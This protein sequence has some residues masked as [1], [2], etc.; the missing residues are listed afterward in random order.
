LMETN[1]PTDNDVLALASSG[2]TVFLGGSFSTVG[3]QVRPGVAAI[4]AA[5]GDVRDWNAHAEGA[6][7]SLALD[8]PRLCV[9]GTFLN[10]GGG[11]RGYLAIL[12][13]ASAQAEAWSM[14]PN[15]PAHAVAICDS[16]VCTAGEF[17]FIGAPRNSLAALDL[18]TGLPT[19]WVPPVFAGEWAGHIQTLAAGGGRLY[20]GGSF[21]MIGDQYRAHLAAFDLATGTLSTWNPEAG[22]VPMAIAPSGGVIYVGGLFRSAGGRTRFGLAAL[23]AITGAATDWNPDVDGSVYSVS[24]QGSTV[25]VGGVFNRLGDIGRHS[26]AAIDAVSGAVSSWNPDASGAV[27][28][29]SQADRTTYVGGD[30]YT[31][32]DARRFGIAALGSM[33]FATPWDPNA[34]GGPWESDYGDPGV[35]CL[36]LDGG[37]V[38]MG[39]NFKKLGGLTRRGIAAVDIAGGVV[40]D[41]D[42]G[43]GGLGSTVTAI[44]VHDGKVCIGGHFESVGSASVCGLA[45]VSAAPTATAPGG[46]AA[47][48]DFE[49]LPPKPNP[50]RGTVALHC[51]IPTSSD[52]T[53]DLFD[54]AGRRVRSLLRQEGLPAGHWEIRLDCASLPS[55]IYYARMVA[56]GHGLT[57]KLVVMN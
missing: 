19:S 46:P 37:T 53:L 52:V 54:C 31:I 11:A 29:I 33:G 5:T 51:S 15:A 56:G 43:L 49:M 25:Y 21:T 2:A 7:Y 42:P 45:V 3:G 4:D 50:A 8:G 16:V 12:D 18:G 48:T 40:E 32:G 1:T 28:A 26:I 27:Y 30:F 55:G 20:V 39:G 35:R 9:A 44:V 17:S 10:I 24:L 14:R 38:Y 34:A 36:T 13:T 22:Q 6:A 23:D 47:M 41:W 57:Q